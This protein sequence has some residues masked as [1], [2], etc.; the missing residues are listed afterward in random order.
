VSKGSVIVVSYL[1]KFTSKTKAVVLYREWSYWCRGE[2]SVSKSFC[3]A[4]L[5]TKFNSL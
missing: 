3:R 4:L 1:D 5:C 2:K